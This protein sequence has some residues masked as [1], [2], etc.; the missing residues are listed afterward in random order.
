MMIA[1]HT[2]IAFIK[3]EMRPILYAVCAILCVFLMAS[4]AVA[5]PFGKVLDIRSGAQDN[6][7][8]FVIESDVQLPYHI[9]TLGNPNRLVIDLPELEW[10]GANSQNSKGQGINRGIMQG[11]RVGL[12]KPGITRVVIDL[13]A[14]AKLKSHFSIPQNDGVGARL[15]IDLVAQAGPLLSVKSENWEAYSQGL[16]Q[17]SL[18]APSP[19][20]RPVPNQRRAKPLIVIDPGHGGV[21][22][23]AISRSGIYEKNIVLTAAKIIQQKMQESGNY[24]VALTRDRD[25]FI[26][27]RKRYDIAQ[28]L[29]ADLFISLHADSHEKKQFRGFSIYTLSDKASDK[30]AAA[31]AT[32][33]NKSDL[34]AGANLDEYTPEVSSIL[35]DLAQQSVNEG[36]WHYAEMLVN[37]LP[38]NVKTLRNPHRFAGFAVLK[39]PN[40]PSVLIELG[41]LSNSQDEANLRRKDYLQAIGNAL[42]KA[43]NAYFERE[44]RLNDDL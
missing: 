44:K 30:E 9:F 11:Y 22:P 14:A 39:S 21:D 31:L 13:D 17:A 25:I 5:A 27:L 33:E 19:L 38:S 2:P 32:K 20:L 37:S 36:S 43:A 24:E 4:A 35:I 28:N 34:I 6:I 26:P 10:Q 23:G 29:Q 42:T 3:F 15:V 1:A 12:F 8:R 7:S 41:Y 40:I 18:S 16:D